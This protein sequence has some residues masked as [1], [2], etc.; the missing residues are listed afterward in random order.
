MEHEWLPYT[1]NQLCKDNLVSPEQ[2]AEVLCEDLKVPTELIMAFTPMIAKSIR[3]QVYDYYQHSPLELKKGPN[4]FTEPESPELRIKIKL[5]IV[6]GNISLNDTIE[7][8]V[9]CKRNDPGLCAFCP[10]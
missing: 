5:D 2:F 1:T 9:N 6:V 7:W 10:I 3:E 8:D 4:V